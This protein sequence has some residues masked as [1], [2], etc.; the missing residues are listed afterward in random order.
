MYV[1]HETPE[2][3]DR[4]LREVL[5]TAELTVLDGTF[6]FEEWPLDAFPGRVRADAL[7]IVRDDEQWSQ[8]VSSSA[9]DAELFALVCLHFAPGLDNSGFV[10][11]LAS[12]LKRRLGTGVFVICGQNSARGGIFDYWGCPA[13]LRDAVLEELEALRATTNAAGAP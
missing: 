3:T 6:A 9:P 13:H 10:G 4:R 2:E 7:A 11:W 1:S 5:A 12:W 8:L